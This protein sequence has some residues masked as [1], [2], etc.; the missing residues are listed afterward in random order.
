MNKYLLI[1]LLVAVIAGITGYFQ[2]NKSHN[3]TKGTKADYIMSPSALLEAYDKNES[4][5]DSLYLDK[6]IEVE[7]TIKTI[8]QAEKGSS[9]SLN[10]GNDMSSVTCEFESD[11]ALSGL[12]VGDKVK[13]KGFCSGKLMDIV[14][15]RCSL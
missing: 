3:E 10:A 7:G 6:I 14:L 12:K 9:L 8:N 5:A 11:T 2:Y 4:L 13:I 1:V 15:V